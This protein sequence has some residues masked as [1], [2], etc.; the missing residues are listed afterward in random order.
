M[1]VL[2]EKAASLEP[3]RLPMTRLSCHVTVSFPG[4]QGKEEG[5]GETKHGAGL[6]GL[7]RR[8]RE[9]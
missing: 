3:S 5:S 6:A 7:G 4:L 9:T 1:W 2:M 8:H